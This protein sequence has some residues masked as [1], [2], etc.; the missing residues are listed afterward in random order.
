[1]VYGYFPSPARSE[2]ASA[3]HRHFPNLPAGCN[4]VIQHRC[5]LIVRPTR[6]TPASFPTDR[7]APAERRPRLARGLGF[8][9]LPTTLVTH[10]SPR[11]ERPR[12]RRQ[13]GVALGTPFT[14]IPTRPMRRRVAGSHPLT[15]AARSRSSGARAA[16]D[17]N[18]RAGP[19]RT[20]ADA[21]AV[22]RREAARIAARALP[23]A[24]AITLTLADALESDGEDD[25]D[26]R[27][28]YTFLPPGLSSPVPWSPS[29]VSSGMSR[30]PG[31]R[32]MGFR[33]L[34]RSALRAP[35]DVSPPG[36]PVSPSVS[37]I[38]THHHFP[39]LDHRAGGIADED[40]LLGD[41]MP[42]PGAWASRTRIPRTPGA[43]RLTSVERF[44]YDPLYH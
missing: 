19:S 2:P 5:V 1:M 13:A 10:I 12:L 7:T 11:P 28:R 29:P 36:A 42:M 27:L 3:T 18:A 17:S 31:P 20:P 14:A 23:T 22:R 25:E 30:S 41:E 33:V 21:E 8:G 40:E 9:G 24:P 37:R 44:A 35:G 16:G 15:V 43:P 6:S 38:G 4:L 39:G 26:E 34:G 32:P